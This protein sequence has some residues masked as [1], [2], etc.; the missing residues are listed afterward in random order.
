M[1]E[2]PS[3]QNRKKDLHDKIQD[4]RLLICKA[5]KRAFIP[6]ASGLHEDLKIILHQPS[7]SSAVLPAGQL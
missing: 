2:A 1:D 5:G 4:L 6:G 7:T 3:R